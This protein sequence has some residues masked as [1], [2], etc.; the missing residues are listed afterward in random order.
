ML[1]TVLVLGALWLL[2]VAIP[3]ALVL[4]IT[5]KLVRAAIENE[6]FNE[7]LTALEENPWVQAGKQ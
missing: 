3:V 4:W 7:R 6:K 2:A 1:S 5:P